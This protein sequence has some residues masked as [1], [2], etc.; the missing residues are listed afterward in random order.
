MG[1]S[2]QFQI[3]DLAVCAS[4]RRLRSPV[5]I[6]ARLLDAQRSL[7]MREGSPGKQSKARLI[8]LIA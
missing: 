6:S 8:K 5:E 1:L 3:Y 4:A 2:L 7:N